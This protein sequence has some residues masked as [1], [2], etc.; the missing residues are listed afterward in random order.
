MK[1]LNKKTQENFTD[2]IIITTLKW[3]VGKIE[4]KITINNIIL[5]SREYLIFNLYAHKPRKLQN[6][7]LKAR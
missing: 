3:H 2:V 6:K 5:K 1:G 4:K 7:I